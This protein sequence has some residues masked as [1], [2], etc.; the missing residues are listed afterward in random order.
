VSEHS[1]ETREADGTA[2]R[3]VTGWEPQRR[4]F[5]LSIA[6]GQRTVFDQRV[7]GG[8][9]SRRDFAKMIELLDTFGISLPRSMIDE[10]VMDGLCEVDDKRVQWKPDGTAV[11]QSA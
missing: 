3:V 6:R 11:R 7:V 2:L 5:H 1:F 4:G 9:A 10:V 8:A